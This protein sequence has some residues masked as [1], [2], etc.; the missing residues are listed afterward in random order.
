[1]LPA[2]LSLPA[3]LTT[4]LGRLTSTR[5][6][7]LDYLDV[8]ISSRS[9]LTQAQAASGVWASA[10]RTLTS[11]PSVIKSVQRGTIQITSGTQAWVMITQVVPAKTFIVSSYS[12]PWDIDESS[13][14]RLSLTLD[15]LSVR[16]D[17]T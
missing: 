13:R 15:G 10:T 6:T 5:A 3:K 17:R 9:S 14:I 8:A 2:L 7:K 11:A 4:L 12:G 16:A 1:M